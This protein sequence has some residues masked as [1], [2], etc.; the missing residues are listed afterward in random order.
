MK[1]IKAS[2]A[3]VV[4]VLATASMGAANASPQGSSKVAQTEVQAQQTVVDLFAPQI[5]CCRPR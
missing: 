2:V 4:A 3:V 5:K 1:A